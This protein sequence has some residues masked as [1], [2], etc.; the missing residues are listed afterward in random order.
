MDEQEEKQEQELEPVQTQEE[1]DYIEYENDE[2]EELQKKERS[3]GRK[4]GIL[5]SLLIVLVT[6]LLCLIVSAGRKLADG[7]LLGTILKMSADST[8][9][10]ITDSVEEKVNVLKTAIDYYYLDEVSDEDLQSGLYKG[11]LEGLSDPYSVYYTEK[12]YNEMMESSGGT[13]SGIGAYLQQ[14]AETM[15]IKVLRPIP[16]TPAEEAGLLPD[17]ILKEVDGEDISSED[18]NVVVSKI[19]GETGTKVCVGVRRAGE[20][21]LLQLEMERRKVEIITV[22]HEMLED[23]IG[24]IEILEFDDVTTEQ[25]KTAFEDL[26]EQ[27]MKS[28]ILDLRDNPGG[29]LDVVVKIAD[30]LLPEGLI[31]YT[32]DKYGTKEEFSSD[33]NC[34]DRPMVVLVNGNSASASEILAGAIKDYD[35]G[36]LLGTT[37]YGKGIV[38]QIIP[39]G[40]G[41]GIKLTVSKYYTPSGKNIHEIGIEPDEILEF[42]YDAYEKDETDN[43]RDRAIELLK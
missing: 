7:T 19:K 37:T 16:G 5:I 10:V 43:Q 20:D 3:R 23:K 12:E 8:E 30:M 17:D 31:V 4:E 13:Y 24:Y 26:Q 33:A 9:E 36:T 28:L 2:F 42:D 35:V 14:D 25:F 11:L 15:E 29:N 21:E 18:I 32:Q 39:L 34:F 41:T 40:D 6:A 38:Q 27:G 22:E 1:T